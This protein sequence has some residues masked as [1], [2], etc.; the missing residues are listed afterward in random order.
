MLSWRAIT[1]A[2]EDQC[3]C[4]A[5]LHQARCA[6]WRCASARCSGSGNCEISIALSS[7]RSIAI[8]RQP[9]QLRDIQ[10]RV[11]LERM[12]HQLRKIDRPEQTRAISGKWLFAAIVR[13]QS[14]RIERVYPG[15]AAS[16]TSA[17]PSPVQRLN[18]GYEGLAVQRAGKRARA[19]RSGGSFWPY[20]KSR[21]ALRTAPG[22]RPE[23]T[24][25][26]CAH[27]DSRA[28]RPCRREAHLMPLGPA[29]SS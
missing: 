27:T 2:A 12:L 8:R 1:C 10:R 25:S 22:Y 5:R 23:T 29:P 16:N 19:S 15:T 24:S 7:S 26:C 11:L 14:V 13:P 9:L 3:I 20:R 28:S 17:S 21:R 4:Q 18:G 6:A